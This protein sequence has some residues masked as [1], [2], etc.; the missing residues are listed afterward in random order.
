MLFISLIQCSACPATSNN[1]QEY[2]EHLITAHSVVKTNLDD[3]Y[4][5]L[6][7][8]VSMTELKNHLNKYWFK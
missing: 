8:T 3:L 1:Q 6:S 2:V 5:R 4:C 7:C